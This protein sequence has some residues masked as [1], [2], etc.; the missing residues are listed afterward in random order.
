MTGNRK[1]Q[2][3]LAWVGAARLGSEKAGR[4]LSDRKWEQRGVGEV[5][6]TAS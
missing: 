1:A 2:Y 5:D 3:F 4:L 6:Q